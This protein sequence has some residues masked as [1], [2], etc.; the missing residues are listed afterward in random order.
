VL[1]L[2]ACS[3]TYSAVLH[4]RTDP[5]PVNP[6]LG[7]TVVVIDGLTVETQRG[8][9]EDA[10][11][12]VTAAISRMR[13]ARLIPAKQ[14]QRTVM[15]DLSRASAPL[16]RE[17]LGTLTKDAAFRSRAATAGIRYIIAVGGYTHM[18]DADLQSIILAFRWQRTT[19]LV[20]EIVD[21]ASGESLG[22]VDVSVNGSADWVVH[23]FPIGTFAF[24]ESKACRKLGS[25]VVDFLGKGS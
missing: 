5:T 18:S 20:A 12:C 23:M 16:D 17:S 8:L 14:C 6:V 22:R 3:R 4:T 13:Q 25:G 9:G 7:V 11:E 21:V 10:A 2:S 19:T 1:S 15:P 24:T